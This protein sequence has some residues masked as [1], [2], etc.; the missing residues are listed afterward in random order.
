[1]GF[2]KSLT[3]LLDSRLN[4]KVHIGIVVAVFA[5]GNL[6]KRQQ[7]RRQTKQGGEA[8]VNKLAMT[9]PGSYDGCITSYGDR[10][11][12]LTPRAGVHCILVQREESALRFG[13]GLINDTAFR[14]EMTGA[15]E[16]A[17]LNENGE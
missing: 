6:R 3:Y 13:P 4:D 15:V 12:L 16:H 9:N 8:D 14:H 2:I 17:L 7:K 5:T 10:T 1:M 11:S